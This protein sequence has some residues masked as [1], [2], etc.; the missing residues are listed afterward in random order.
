VPDAAS[1]LGGVCARDCGAAG[2]CEA[3]E[4]CRDALSASGVMGAQC[5][6]VAGCAQ[7]CADDPHEEGRGANNSPEGALPLSGALH[8]LRDLSVCPGDVDF[9]RLAV[10]AGGALSAALT[11]DHLEGDLDLAVTLEGP[12]GGLADS[13]VSATSDQERVALSALCGGDSVALVEVYG[14]GDASARYDL[15]LTVTPA[16]PGACDGGCAA[17]AG[18]PLGQRC[19]AGACAPSACGDQAC[20][21]GAV[22][23]SPRAGRVPRGVSGLCAEPCARDEECR[24]GEACKRFEDLS[25]YCAPVGDSPVGGPCDSFEE[26]AGDMICFFK[27]IGFCASGGCAARPC[28]ANTACAAVLGGDACVPTCA[29]EGESC[30]GGRL[31][32]RRAPQGLVCVP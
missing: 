27:G 30:E 12:A 7:R 31:T 20:G 19:E 10:P 5:L 25:A 17:T 29:T 23:V 9:F 24:A 15:A 26:C 13:S 18:C 32:C 11:F 28:P 2:A 22:C 16:A 14:Y 1:P 21:A 4:E 8:D 6:R 3:G